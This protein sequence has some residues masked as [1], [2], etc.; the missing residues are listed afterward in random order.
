M[1]FYQKL[2]VLDEKWSA[3]LVLPEQKSLLRSLLVF[4]GHSCDSWYWLIG[5]ALVWVLG[6]PGLKSHATFWMFGL[7]L[8]AVFVL[9]MKFLIHRPRPE[10]EWG[11]IYRVTDPHS[12]PSGHAAR[13]IAIAVMA[14]RFGSNGLVVGLVIWAILVGISRVALKL[15]YLSDILIGWLLGLISGLVAITIYPE[16]MTL[17]LGLFQ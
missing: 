2:L 8:L 11:Q 12:F 6:N 9:L 5:L 4:L 13:A 3:R 7:V 17:L 15:H 16:V 14:S 10:G 1:S